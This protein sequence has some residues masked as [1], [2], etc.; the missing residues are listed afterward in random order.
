VL[1]TR[2]SNEAS[3]VKT[4]EDAKVEGQSQVEESKVNQMP[5]NPYNPEEVTKAGEEAKAGERMQA[6]Q[7]MPVGHEMQAGMGMNT[8]QAT[9]NVQVMN[10]GTGM[11]IGRTMVAAEAM[12]FDESTKVDDNASDSGGHKPDVIVAWGKENT[13]D[14]NKTEDEK[15]ARRF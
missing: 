12:K 5:L 13:V 8:E 10:V 2:K 4:E 1:L 3:M 11:Q 6:G 9:N 7:E 14:G 15:K